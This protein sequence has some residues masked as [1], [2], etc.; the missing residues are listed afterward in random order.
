LPF[1][2]VVP[3]VFGAWVLTYALAIRVS[4]TLARRGWFRTR[5]SVQVV[6]APLFFAAFGLTALLAQVLG[7]RDEQWRDYLVLDCLLLGFTLVLGVTAV[8]LARR[9]PVPARS[10]PHAGVNRA[11][12]RSFRRGARLSPLLMVL[13]IAYWFLGYGWVAD[14]VTAGILAYAVLWIR[15]ALLSAAERLEPADVRSTAAPVL[16]IRP[17]DAELRLFTARETFEEFFAGVLKP[18]GPVVALGCPGDRV[19]PPGAIRS[20][21][22]DDDWRSAF[23]ETAGRAICIVGTVADS[24]NTSWELGRIRELGRQ[25]ALY[26]FTAPAA[27]PPTGGA[28]RHVRAFLGAWGN[29]DMRYFDRVFAFGRPAP[30]AEPLS[31]MAWPDL[32]ELFGSLGY[33]VDVGDPGPGSVLGFDDAGRMRVLARGGRIAEDFVAALALQ[34]SRRSSTRGSPGG[35]SAT[36][37][38]GAGARRPRPAGTPRRTGPAPRAAGRPW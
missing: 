25:E 37:R 16:Y 9:V 14:A 28:W 29:E 8:L 15:G 30:S 36:S 17:F 2:F 33:R 32:A 11:A 13:A 27:E 7:T 6:S 3:G 5:T 1:L 23:E 38:P 31:E 10:G 26:L 18:L 4:G 12:A 19:P 20:Y 22:R 34:P 35:G 21:Y 24:P